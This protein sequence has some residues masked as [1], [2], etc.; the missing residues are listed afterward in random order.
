[1]EAERGCSRGVY[2]RPRTANQQ[3]AVHVAFMYIIRSDCTLPGRAS[4]CKHRKDKELARNCQYVDHAVNR[5]P[6]PGR[7]LGASQNCA[8]KLSNI[9][10]PSRSL[11]LHDN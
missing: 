2:S 1:M 9:M 4:A 11:P 7:R 5:G 8:T 6:D 3:C 10:Q